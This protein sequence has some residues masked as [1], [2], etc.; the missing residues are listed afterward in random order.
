MLLGYPGWPM[1]PII[2]SPLAYSS[3]CKMDFLI[4]S[5]VAQDIKTVDEMFTESADGSAR[6][7][8]AGRGSK[9]KSRVSS[10]SNEEKLLFLPWRKESDVISPPPGDIHSCFV[11]ESIE[12]ALGWPGKDTNRRPQ[13]G[14]LDH[15]FL[16]A[17][18]SRVFKLRYR[19]Q[20]NSWCWIH[21]EGPIACLF[22]KLLFHQPFNPVSSQSLS[23]WP[24]H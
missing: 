18:S 10:C 19:T 2:F 11:T 20:V 14:H 24:N 8:M 5:N 12:Q 16:K 22:S 13:G 1:D 17:L 3:P 9:S 21:S 7:I 6:R 23:L 15:P 4:F